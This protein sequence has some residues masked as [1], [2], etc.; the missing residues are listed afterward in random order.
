MDLEIEKEA[1]FPPSVHYQFQSFYHSCLMQSKITT[2]AIHTDI[3]ER[4]TTRGGQG[5]MNSDHRIQ[6]TSLIQQ[7]TILT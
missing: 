2:S 6:M 4:P 3:G 1:V 5:V 7:P